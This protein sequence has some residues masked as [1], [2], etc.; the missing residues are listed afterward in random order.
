[1]KIVSKLFYKCSACGHE[2][3]NKKDAM[4]CE[5]KPTSKDRGVKIGDKV[6]IIKGEGQGLATVESIHIKDKYWGHYWWK[7]YWHTVALV[8]KCNDSRGYRVLCW[9]DYKVIKSKLK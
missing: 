4:D 3:T 8:A 5:T 1:M 2:Y 9:D 7:R 6:K